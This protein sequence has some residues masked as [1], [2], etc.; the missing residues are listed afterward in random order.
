M[1]LRILESE[2][3]TD[4]NGLSSLASFKAK[5]KLEL[6]RAQRQLHDAPNP[7]REFYRF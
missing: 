3:L 6:T 7:H 5:L 4:L 1:L 2:S